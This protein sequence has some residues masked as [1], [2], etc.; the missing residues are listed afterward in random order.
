MRIAL[1]IQDGL[2]Q[3]VLTPDTD[4]E[5]NI[6]KKLHD[7]ARALSI[8]SGSFYECQGGWVRHGNEDDSTFLV[9]RAAPTTDREE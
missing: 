8:K 3:I 7:G 5:R 4:T 6:L 1:Y 9:L 2:E